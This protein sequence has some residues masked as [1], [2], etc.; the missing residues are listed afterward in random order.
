MNLNVALV[1]ASAALGIDVSAH[2]LVAGAD[3]MADCNLSRDR[4]IDKISHP[5]SPRVQT[6]TVSRMPEQQHCATHV[7]VDV[8]VAIDSDSLGQSRLLHV[9]VKF[10]S[11][12]ARNGHAGSAKTRVARI[13]RHC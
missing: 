5:I 7:S 13:D 9:G 12:I 8:R 1:A 11:C 2:S 6:A 10:L 3:A 4:L